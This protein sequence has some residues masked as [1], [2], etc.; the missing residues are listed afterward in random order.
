M[1]NF[2]S[3]K[4]GSHYPIQKVRKA[5]SFQ[6]STAHLGVPSKLFTKKGHYKQSTL[7]WKVLRAFPDAKIHTPTGHT[8]SD[9][10]DAEITFQW[11]RGKDNRVNYNNDKLKEIFGK[12]LE[13]IDWRD[14]NTVE[15]SLSYKTARKT[16]NSV[17][18]K[19]A[20]YTRTS[21]PEKGKRYDIPIQGA[22]MV[23]TDNLG[24]AK[25][26]AKSNEGYKVIYDRMA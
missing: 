18:V 15:L 14:N 1:T 8:L 7:E 13:D 3:R 20:P 24:E 4:D 10:V 22:K 25:K 9:S 16:A 19:Y 5:G 21:V 11:D 2:R 26:I 12:R 17:K 23:S 6:S